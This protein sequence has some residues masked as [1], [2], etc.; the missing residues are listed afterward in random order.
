MG[1][2][3]VSGGSIKYQHRCGALLAFE[4]AALKLCYVSFSQVKKN[5]Q[6]HKWYKDY[7]AASLIAG[8]T[9]QTNPFAYN[10]QRRLLLSKL[11]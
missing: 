5:M 1:K 2:P 10:N 9:V 11:K 8:L 7:L 3:A 4:T 6:K